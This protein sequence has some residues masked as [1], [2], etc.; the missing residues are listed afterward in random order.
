VAFITPGARR[1]K[2]VQPKE[3]TLIDTVAQKGWKGGVNEIED[4]FNVLPYPR[5]FAKALERD[6]D[7]DDA[8]HLAVTATAF[9][10]E[11]HI[12]GDDLANEL[13]EIRRTS[14]RLVSFQF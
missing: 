11:E 9:S 3:L 2:T 5:S 6:T 13:P 10:V 7:N 4:V 12:E 14:C 8:V 1:T